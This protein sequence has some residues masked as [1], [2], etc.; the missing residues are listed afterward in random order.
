MKRDLAAA[1]TVSL[2]LHAA[3]LGALHVATL[4]AGRDMVLANA[5]EGATAGGGPAPIRVVMSDRAARKIGAG[6]A[7][8]P[9][10]ND[11][12]EPLSATAPDTDVARAE[13]TGHASA[14]KQQAAEAEGQEADSDASGDVSA[15]LGRAGDGPAPGSPARDG[16]PAQPQTD[17]P[18]RLAAPVEPEYPFRARRLGHEG[19]VA[20]T[21]LVGAG[22]EVLDITLEESSGH[23][24]LDEAARAA[25]SRAFYVAGSSR[26]PMPLRVV[27]VFQLDDAG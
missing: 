5:G 2:V 20:F 21:V 15:D 23:A 1:I 18:P 25:I 16:L 24:E 26:S 27:V 4:P 9:D 3:L 13:S 17:R 6:R 19:T 12:G 8:R 10:R 22:G 14:A 11:R 7:D